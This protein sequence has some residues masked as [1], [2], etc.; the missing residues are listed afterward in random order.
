MREKSRLAICQPAGSPWA[1]RPLPA[2]AKA[3]T[4][5]A[6]VAG[7][8]RTRLESDL[9]AVVLPGFDGVSAAFLRTQLRA[10]GTAG[11]QEIEEGLTDGGFAGD[12]VPVELRQDGVVGL[13]ELM[14]WFE[15][16]CRHGC[17]L[18]P[19]RGLCQQ[20]SSGRQRVEV[21]GKCHASHC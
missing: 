7:F 8:V 21:E 10:N 11:A 12:T 1:V 5:E 17:F 16:Q 13:D 4:G 2:A 20:S 14:A 9:G 18:Y 19:K 15:F 3:W 6:S